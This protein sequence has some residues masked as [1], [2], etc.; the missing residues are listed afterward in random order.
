MFIYIYG[1]KTGYLTGKNCE[2]L[3]FL[4]ITLLVALPEAS[5]AV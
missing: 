1:K 2:K 3:L 4:S 5:I